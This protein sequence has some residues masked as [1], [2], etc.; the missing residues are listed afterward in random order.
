[1]E[2]V[3][4]EDEEK[5]PK[6]DEKEQSDCWIFKTWKEVAGFPQLHFEK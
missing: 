4:G 2:S 3:S 1:L 5:E 6:D